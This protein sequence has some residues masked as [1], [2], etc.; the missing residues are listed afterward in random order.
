MNLSNKTVLL[1]GGTGSFGK[2]FVEIALQE[3]APKVIRV[4]SRDELKQF[5]MSRQFSDERLRFFIGDVRDAN[6][7]SRAMNDVD[8]VVHAAA[9]KQVPACEYNPIEAVK[10]N[11]NGAINVIDAAIDNGIEKVIALSTDK[12]VHPVNLYGATKLVAEKL[13]IQGNAYVGE[14]GTRFSC[15]RYGNV[16]GSRGSVIP[17]FLAQREQGVITMT[18]K[19]MT[20]FWITLEQGVRFVIACLERMKGG[21]VFVPKIPSMKLIDLAEVI[22]PEAR[23]QFIGIRPG[24]KIHETL[25]TEEEA[26]HTKEFADYCVIEPEQAFWSRDNYGHGKELPD[27]FQYASDSNKHW[28]NHEELR[29]FVTELS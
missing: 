26:R 18:D 10:T 7:L 8:I 13:F 28:L 22:A 9:L 23:K 11:I 24:E 2:K 6:R 14:R 4:F 17:L 1:T 25:I 27:G 21:E 19:R 20:R 5:E 29:Q 12:A 15:V 16:V 3:C